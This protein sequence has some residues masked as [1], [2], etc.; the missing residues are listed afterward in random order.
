MMMKNFRY[1]LHG[2]DQRKSLLTARK[3]WTVLC[4]GEAA[5]RIDSRIVTDFDDYDVLIIRGE[6]SEHGWTKQG[7]CYVVNS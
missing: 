2:E 1:F 6:C 4:P 7:D 3:T 5:E